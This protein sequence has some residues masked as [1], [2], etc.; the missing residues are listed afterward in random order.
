M[1]NAEFG[2]PGEVTF[3]TKSGTNQLHGAAFWYHQNSAFDATPFGSLTKPH[4]VGNDFGG[5][6]GGPV[7][8]PHLYNGRDKTFFFGTYEGFRLPSTTTE[9]YTVP[10]T[11]M[12]QGNFTGVA[13][14][15]NP[16]TGT[17]YPND[18][19]PINPVSQ[20]FL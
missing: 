12:K 17:P 1:N 2:Q 4:I 16:F 7:V 19:M 10:S 15:V 9:Q 20:K 13:T 11:L 6:L 8:I 18:T 5:T 14:V 3:V